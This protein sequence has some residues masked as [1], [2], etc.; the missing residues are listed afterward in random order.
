M[1]WRILASG[2]GGAA[3]IAL[4]VW[5]GDG[6]IG[7]DVL[8]AGWAIPAIVA[9]HLGQVILSGCAWRIAV[10]SPHLSL[11]TFYRLRLI[12]EGINSLLPVAQVGGQIVCIRLM[13]QQ[14]AGLALVS[15][16]TVLD[17]TVETGMQLV[18]VILGVA[19]LTATG[20][21]PFS[22]PWVDGGLFVSALGILA[23]IVAQRA[24][25]LRVIELAMQRLND[26]LPIASAESLRGLHD[27]L[28][29]LQ[30]RTRAVIKASTVH[31]SSWSLGS[32]EVYLVLLAMG[33]PVGL[34][35]AFVIES[36][37]TAARSAGFA[38]PGALGVQEGGFILV[39]GLF[40]VP[41]D[42]AIALSMV[43]RLREIL[44]GVPGLFIWQWSEIRRRLWVPG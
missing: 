40:G 23:F 43:K 6:E 17:Q 44:L 34:P 18:F 21:N 14:G 2:F 28:M 5:F 12:R 7:S 1:R 41:P 38:I 36:L 26:F 4:I 29:R 8:R 19:M 25:V 20:I 30:G 11:P 32:A 37:G 42:A 22:V 39:C 35:Q 10:G 31:L 3:L 13:T 15:A 16:G 27:E 9:L 24:G 33:A